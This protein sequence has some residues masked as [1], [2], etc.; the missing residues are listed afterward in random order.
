MTSVNAQQVVQPLAATGPTVDARV[1]RS[2]PD[3][4]RYVM[5]IIPLALLLVTF[6][7]YRLE[8]PA[9]FSLACLVFGGFAVSYWLPFRFKETFLVVLSLGGAYVLLSPLVASLLIAVGL[10]LFVIIR[11][12]L[13]FRW[14]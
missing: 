13:E 10:S 9:F 1:Q 6:K 5:L 12:R 14:R 4:R 3:V 11:S 2:K 8:Q 7:V